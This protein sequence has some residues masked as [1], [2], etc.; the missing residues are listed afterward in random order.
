MKFKF[1]YIAVVA[2][3]LAFTSCG[4][5]FL[6]VE[7]K[8]LALEENYYKNRDEAYNGLVAIYDVLGFTQGFVSKVG[9]LNSASDDHYAGGGGP[10]DMNAFQVWSNYSLDPSVGP[11]DALW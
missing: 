6:Q 9:S 5:D 11:Q 1:K 3:V 8:G 4:D 7:P 10:T 2:G